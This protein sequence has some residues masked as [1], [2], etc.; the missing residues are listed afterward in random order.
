[1]H[2][3]YEIASRTAKKESARSKQGYDRIIHGATIQ[4]GGRV[5][6]RNLS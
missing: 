6:V 1:M 3:A 2:Q 5:L 4:P